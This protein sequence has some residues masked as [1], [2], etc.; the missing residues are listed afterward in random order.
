MA[1]TRYDRNAEARE[2]G[3]RNYY[4]VRI[5]G[6]ITAA[7]RGDITPSTP[8]P[9]GPELARTRGHREEYYLQILRSVE[10][11]STI[12]VGTNLGNIDRNDAGD[13][14]DIPVVAIDSD[15]NEYEFTLR[16]MSDEELAWFIEE[17]DNLDVDYDTDYD[18]AALLPAGY[19]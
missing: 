19:R 1:P 11:G 18:L 17:L 14:E 5:R 4:E 10:R 16:D 12:M 13:W 3:F 6:G 2:L 15:M 7:R 8:R 9:E